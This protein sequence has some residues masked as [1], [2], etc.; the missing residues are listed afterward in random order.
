MAQLAL[1]LDV[2][3]RERALGLARELAG[4]VPWCKVGLALFTL[5]GPA[6]PEALKNMGYKIFLDLKFYDIPRTVGQAVR[7]AAACGAD[8]LTV[9]CQ[10]G[11]R[12][13]LAAV[14]NLAGMERRPL[15]FGV[16]A[17]TSFGQGEM[18]G[19]AADPEDFALSL[20]GRAEAWGLDGVVCSGFEV[21]HVKRNCPD[22][23]CLVPGIRPAG[24]VE[25]DQRR[26][27][28]P[29]A[30]VKDGA[31]FLVAGRPIIESPSPRSAAEKILQEMSQQK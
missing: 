5:V 29:A 24:L 31:D 8:M 16:T 30:A 25:D 13:C 9:H 21:A 15:I 10:G 19:V 18:P 7:A 14:E 4:L 22:L 2:L 12:M 11:E 26:V 6:L 20:A 27:V 1:A 3:S 28:T 17:L 23:L